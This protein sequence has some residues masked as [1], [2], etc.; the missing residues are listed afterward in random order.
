MLQAAKQVTAVCCVAEC[1]AAAAA[2]TSRT[3]AGGV[4]HAPR[5]GAEM[6]LVGAN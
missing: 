2:A 4:K 1:Q 6:W 5:G 3:T